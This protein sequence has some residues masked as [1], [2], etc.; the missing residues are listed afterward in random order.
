MAAGKE[1]AEAADKKD[2]REKV[3]EILRHKN[4]EVSQKAGIFERAPLHCAAECGW[5]DVV[6]LLLQAKVPTPVGY[7]SS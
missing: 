1:L 3:L 5:A 4:P 6:A 2:N 7:L